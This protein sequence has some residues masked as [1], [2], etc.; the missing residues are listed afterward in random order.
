MDIYFKS[1]I[2]VCSEFTPIG[3]GGEKREASIV[4]SPL[5]VFTENEKDLK[6]T[7]G[8]N[9]WKGCQNKSCR[10]A[11]VSHAVKKG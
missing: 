2:G 7:M 6:I 3:L 8:C 9:L 5:K 4:I 10:F 1:D 11:E